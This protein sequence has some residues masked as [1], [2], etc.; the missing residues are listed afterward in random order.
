MPVLRRCGLPG[1]TESDGHR[2]WTRDVVDNNNNR[3]EQ[4]ERLSPKQADHGASELKD[5][6]TS[7]RT[8]V[9]CDTAV[10]GSS[11]NESDL[12]RG[13]VSGSTASHGCQVSDL[14]IHP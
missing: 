6:S 12:L 14:P 11:S 8:A 7:R 13:R 2:T 5:R 9:G 10:S 4:P 3:A 1:D